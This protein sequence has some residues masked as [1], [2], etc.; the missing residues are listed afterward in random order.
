MFR[1]GEVLNLQASN[2]HNAHTPDFI[3]GFRVPRFLS[4]RYNLELPAVLAI[5]DIS[6]NV[7]LM[8]PSIQ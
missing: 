7:R 3:R 1:V 8:F 4:E 6:L 5:W 2:P